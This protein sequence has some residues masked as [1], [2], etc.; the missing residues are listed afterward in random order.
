MGKVILYSACSLDGFIARKD[1]AIDWLFTEGD[2]GYND[3]LKSIETTIMGRKTFEQVLTFGPFEYNHLNNFI[4]STSA[5]IP[6]EINAQRISSGIEQFTT[7]LKTKSTKNI[8][9]VG[10]G[11][12]N[13][14]LLKA[15]LIDELILS[16]HP[17]ILGEG[18]PLFY[19][20]NKQTNLALLNTRVYQGGLAQHTYKVLNP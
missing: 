9:L 18:I 1:G 14:V 5:K 8:W 11:E 6:K 2:F 20:T 12:I 7:E 10:G 4:Y 13:T 3:F 17:I 16:I 19:S 15:G